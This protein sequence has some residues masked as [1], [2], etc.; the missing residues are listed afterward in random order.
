MVA[1]GGGVQRRESTMKKAVTIPLACMV[2]AALC[3]GVMAP[4]ARADDVR[5]TLDIDVSKPGA[6]IPKT[7]YGLMTEEI[8]HSYD[9][10]LFAELIQNRT[11]QDPPPRGRGPRGGPPQTLPQTP[12]TQPATQGLPIH[13]SLIGDGK[14][15]AVREDPVN[16]ALPVS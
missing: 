7:F 9:G 3:G 4:V 16:A 8:N 11:F 5:A 13:W 1:A 6:M 14:A 15:T 12:P 10:G 2:I